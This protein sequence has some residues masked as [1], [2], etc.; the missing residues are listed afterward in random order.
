MKLA[1]PGSEFWTPDGGEGREALAR[2]T[3]LAIGAHA[4]DV[5]LMAVS[6]I[7][8]CFGHADRAL[9]AVIVTDGAGS[10]RSGPHAG[11]TNEQMITLRRREQKK[12]ALVGEYAS[13]VLLDYPSHAVQ[14]GEPAIAAD[15]ATVLYETRPGITVYTHALTDSHDTH[16]GTAL[17]VIEACR[18]LDPDR[19]PSKLL[20]C[21]VWRGL[22]WLPAHLQVRMNAGDRP[23]LQAALL[24]VFDSQIAS[25]KRYDLAALGQRRAR[26][27]YSASHDV[28]R[29]EGVV[30]GMDMTPLIR[31][32]TT[33]PG[34]FASG[35][36]R[37]FERDVLSRIGRL[38]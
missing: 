5:E 32:E 10:A 35:L 24:G 36:I 12:A 26:A 8:E 23:H 14:F 19:R 30:L 22:D 28:D 17:R 31:D 29:Q 20:G 4:D 16:V 9:S 6:G 7:L 13:L 37:A 21:E 34:D 11:L 33:S 15:L 18:K 25:G 27:T 3:H 38:G 1:R 2:T